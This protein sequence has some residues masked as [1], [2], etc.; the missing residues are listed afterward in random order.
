LVD[1]DPR[2][3]RQ[4]A[5]SARELG[6]ASKVRTARV[7]L[8]GDPAAAVRRL[9]ETGRPFDLVFADAPYSEIGSVPR[10]LEA[11]VASERLSPGAWVVVERPSAHAWSWPN[12][13]ASEADYRYGRT[14]ISL[15][16]FA[17]EKGRH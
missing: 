17:P 15:G 4:I 9:P 12:G 6:L 2:A 5:Q 10:L 11:L 1:S 14:S 16:V 13:L 7:D 8:V 3:V